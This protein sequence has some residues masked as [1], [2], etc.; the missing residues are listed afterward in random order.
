MELTGKQ[1]IEIL[2]DRLLKKGASDIHIVIGYPPALRIKGDLEF[3]PDLGVIDKERTLKVFDF[4]SEML[5]MEQVRFI[6][7]RLALDKFSNAGF[8][9]V[10]ST[11]VGTKRYRVQ[12][13]L[14]NGGYQI[15]LREIKEVPPEL[16]TLGFDPETLQG[17]RYVISRP[18]GLF[19]VVGATGSGKSTTLAS[20]IREYSLLYPKKVITLEDP[21][22][23]LH[24]KV[25]DKKAL[26]VQRELGRD[27]FRFADGLHSA[28]R[29]DPDSILVG[30]IRDSVSLD[31]ALKASETGHLVFSTLHTNNA[32]ETIRRLT[33]MMEGKEKEIRDRLSVSLVGILAQRLAK[34]KDGNGRVV[35]YELFI[36]DRGARSIIRAGKD[37]QL[38][39]LIDTMKY[40]NS[41]L[42]CVAGRVIREEIS[43]EEAETLVADPNELEKMIELM[44]HGS[45]DS[46]ALSR[47]DGL[48][49]E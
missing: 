38:V 35:V 49:I 43:K 27:F 8:A 25:E 21:I 3:E 18:Y 37:E 23:Y 41:F 22:E 39:S 29:E 34:R 48:V 7:E 36:P 31:L 14:H 10:I 44:S 32:I 30:E 9:V 6:K 45:R 11:Q 40:S 16:S 1:L 33:A 15:V 47:D 4:L 46:S 12:V 28:L 24:E 17:L 13:S 26:V 42:S 19:L 20:M 2:H 5:P